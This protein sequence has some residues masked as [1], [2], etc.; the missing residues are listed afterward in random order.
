MNPATETNE[1]TGRPTI[2]R[3][4]RRA[5]L[6]LLVMLALFAVALTTACLW[7]MY[8]R[9]AGQQEAERAAAAMSPRTEEVAPANPSPSPVAPR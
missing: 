5:N 8:A 1:E 3:E 7:W 2:P 4:V 6:R 9:M